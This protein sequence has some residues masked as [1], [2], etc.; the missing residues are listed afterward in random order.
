MIPGEIS[1]FGLEVVV[2]LHHPLEMLVDEGVQPGEVVLIVKDSGVGI[3]AC[4]E[5]DE[6]LSLLCAKF[7]S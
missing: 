1:Y 5:V 3:L 4:G 6:V 2:A 7:D